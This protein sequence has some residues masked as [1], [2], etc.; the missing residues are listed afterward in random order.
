[1][2]WETLDNQLRTLTKSESE[3]KNGSK[4]SI[5]N[6]LPHVIRNGQSIPILDFKSNLVKSAS[7]LIMIKKHS[8][9][10]ICPTH[11]HNW[12]EINYMYS[13]K[14]PQII[15]KTHYTLQK[16]QL[17]LIDCETPHSTDWVGEDDI[18]ISLV[19][20]KDFLSTN[21][22]NRLS[23]DSIVSKFFINAINKDTDHNNYIIFH[24]E[25]SRR[26]PIFFNELLCEI[27]DPSINSEDIINSLL[28][29]ILGELINVYDENNKKSADQEY[30]KMVI[31]ILHY[32]EAN[33]K[34]C[35]L[36]TTA[37]YF[38]LNP[39]YLT[40]YLK[41][42]TGTSYK[43]LIQDQKMSQ[44]IKYLKNSDMIISE[45]AHQVGYENLNF[46]YKK[47]KEYYQCTPKEYRNSLNNS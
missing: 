19:I 11:I 18:M 4:E 38:N 20:S 32:I 39:N 6:T 30:H 35:S 16:G 31:P 8:R 33:Y 7:N 24:S 22:F 44:S 25:K 13:G 46:F 15:N 37:D 1:M 47:F 12:I 34:T 27:Y 43:Q 9:Y 23:N 29:I 10:Q 5:F 36:E 14:C 40:T 42:M 3:Y 17:I 21:F 26:L 28:M 45:I 2:N 41:K